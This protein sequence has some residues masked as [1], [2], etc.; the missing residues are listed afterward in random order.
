MEKKLEYSFDDEPVSK[1]CYDLERKKIEVYFKG[2]FDVSKDQYLE[3]S[4]IWSI[5][6]WEEAKCTIGNDTKLYDIEEIIGIFSL[7]LYMKFNEDDKLEMYV[8]TVDNRYLTLFFKNP[9]L[10][11]NQK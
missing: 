1:F 10:C 6:N 2:Y 5:E 4:C 7:I 11:L 9:S 8:I 3:N